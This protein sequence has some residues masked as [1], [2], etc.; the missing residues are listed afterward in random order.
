[1]PSRASS[2]K[3]ERGTEI[4]VERRDGGLRAD[5]QPGRP[6]DN[7]FPRPGELSHRFAP[8]F[9]TAAGDKR[10]AGKGQPKKI[11]TTITVVSR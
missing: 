8:A 1:M 5:R 11:Y 10:P 3:C 6:V 4:R 7:L 2:L 9:I